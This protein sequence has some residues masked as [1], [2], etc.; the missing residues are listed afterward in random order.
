MTNASDSAKTSPLAERARRFFEDLQNTITGAIERLDG[1]SQFTEDVWTFDDRDAAPEKSGGGKTRVLAHGTIFEKAGVNFS[2]VRSPLSATLA[3]RLQVPPQRISA[4][5]ISLVLHPESPMIPTVHMN[6][7]YLELGDGRAW[8]GGGSDLTPYYFFEEDARHFHRVLREACDRHDHTWY[9]RFKTWCDEYFYLPHRHE[10]RG[11]GGLFFDDLS[12]D[13]ERTFA[14][15]QDVG[16]SFL[17]AYLPIVERRR[18]EKW[19][20]EE[21]RWQELR[22]GRYVE[23]NLLHDRGT[24]FGLETGGRI[25]SILMSL[26]PRV[27]WEY[28]VDPQPGTREHALLEILHNPRS[29]I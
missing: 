26:P 17:P 15:V 21:R 24:L 7:R 14:F 11:I 4:T 27:R 3:T 20:A 29:W 23:F 19:G 6:L 13:P 18:T 5:G 9:P 2:S 1:G 16:T 22:R 25:E 28:Q 10:A 8:F 12:A